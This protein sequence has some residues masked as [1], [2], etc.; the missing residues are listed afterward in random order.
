MAYAKPLRI[1]LIDMARGVALIAMTIFHFAFDLEL[2][3]FQKPG[4]TAQPHWK[5]FARA[6]ATSFLFLVGFSLYLAHAQW[7]DWASWRVRML[8]IVGAALLITVATYVATP[9][10][11]IFFGILH[12]IAFSSIAG[13]LFIRSPVLLTVTCAIAVFLIGQGFETPLLDHWTFWW[14]GLSAAPI[15]SSDYVPVFP[16]LSASLLGIAAAKLATQYKLLEKMSVYRAGG[17]PAL[18]LRFLGQNSLVYYLLH[19]PV[20]IALILG[21]GM[22]TGSVQL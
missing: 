8:K 11:Y 7:I 4:F 3:G 16:W 17:K 6:I 15:M 1:D 21:W 13:L 14:T 20:L 10:Q 2:F 5:Y 19:Q 22:M 9:S 18:L 12:A